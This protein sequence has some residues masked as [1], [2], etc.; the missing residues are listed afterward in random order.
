VAEQYR[1]V[2]DHMTIRVRDMER[3]RA[4]YAAALAPLGFGIVA[5]Y[6]GD[7][8]IAFGPPGQDDFAIAPAGEGAAPSGPIHLAF[9]ATD[10][11]AVN[12]FHVFGMS[13]GGRDN[14]SP[15]L[16]PQYH[17]AYYAAYLIDP[18]GNNVEAVHHG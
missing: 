4:F 14:G 10:Q 9:H 16:R 13:A 7:A 12:D 5:D 3:A 2:L 15:G 8:G 18:D 11:A 6:G 17:D 1:R